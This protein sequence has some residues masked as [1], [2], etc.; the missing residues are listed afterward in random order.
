MADV[1][2]NAEAQAAQGSEMPLAGE[3]TA[4]STAQNVAENANSD[5]QAAQ[6]ETFSLEDA[7]KLRSE[8]KSLRSRLHEFE[9][10]AQADADAKLSEQE[11]LQ[12]R[13]SELESDRTERETKAQERVLRYEVRIHAK[14]LGIVD[15]S[16][17]LKLLD[18]SEVE[19]DDDG[20]PKNID[21]LLRDLVRKKP[22]LAGS[23]VAA[24][25]AA[26]PAKNSATAQTFTRAQ[27]ND[28]T[29]F[30][31]HEKAIMAAIREGRV[32]D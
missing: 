28:F 29:F 15:P 13:L 3:Q 11:R 1:A 2:T 22:Y 5:A 32:T 20:E 12:K 30:K 17:A 8:N 10:K 23:A 7:R 25:N 14:D 21:K 4:N 9:S 31:T 26:N 24:S 18:L 6:T 19:Y 16:D 27:L